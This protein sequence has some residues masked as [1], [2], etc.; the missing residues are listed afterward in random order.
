MQRA[1]VPTLDL[2]ILGILAGWA[3]AFIAV[4]CVFS[5]KVAVLFKKIPGVGWTLILKYGTNIGIL[6]EPV[7][8]VAESKK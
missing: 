2:K 4:V 1:I 7:S 6:E 8:P 3:S 5:K